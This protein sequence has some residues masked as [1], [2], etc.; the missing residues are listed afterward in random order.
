MRDQLLSAMPEF[1]LIEDAALREKTIAVWLE[2]LKRGGWTVEDLHRMPFTLLLKPCPLSC[3]EH[4]RGVV[5]TCVEVAS[6]FARIYGDKLPLKRDVLIAGAILHDV[7]KLL[8]YREADGAFSVS[9]MGKLL[10]HPVS[11]AALCYEM[12]LP[13]EVVHIVAVHSKEGDHVKRSPEAVVLHHA[14]F[15]NFETLH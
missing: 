8:E 14:D 7:G 1:N 4:N 15:T 12:G 9:A 13:D 2:A 6:V 3:I 10:R 5:N 11:G